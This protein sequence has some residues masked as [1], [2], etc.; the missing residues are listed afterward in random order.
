M[1]ILIS[2]DDGINAPCL[3][4]LVETFSTINN[5]EVLVI[6]P[7]FE[8]STTGHS[9]NLRRPLQIEELSKN[10]YSLDGFPG[11]CIITGLKYL[12]KDTP[13]DLVISGINRGGNLG[14]DIFYSG[15]VGAAREASFHSIPAIAASL[16]VEFNDKFKDNPNDF[17]FAA[18]YLKQLIINKIFNLIPSRF[19]LNI[20][21]PYDKKIIGPKITKHGLRKY[22]GSIIPIQSPRKKTFF[23]IGTNYQGHEDI[24]NSDCKSVDQGYISITPIGYLT[25]PYPYTTEL[26][27]LLD[28]IS[29]ISIPSTSI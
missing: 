23:W 21:F 9:L 12:W 28:D 14:Q 2:N 6:A 11:D 27:K 7:S 19:Y 18:N 15:T 24:D 10:F 26:Q 13:P 20:N 5:C 1:K 29:L 4:V 8:R 3:K 22:L 25:D 16:A 17:I